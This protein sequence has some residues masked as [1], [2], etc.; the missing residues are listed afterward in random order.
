MKEWR[1]LLDPDY[2]SKS[3]ILQYSYIFDNHRWQQKV[4]ILVCTVITAPIVCCDILYLMDMI[5]DRSL[6]IVICSIETTF[7]AV[8]FILSF[9]VFRALL[10]YHGKY[11]FNQQ[12]KFLLKLPIPLVIVITIGPILSTNIL[13]TTIYHLIVLSEMYMICWIGFIYFPVYI[14][15]KQYNKIQYTKKS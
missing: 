11:Y 13:F 6:A 7:F 4:S 1:K 2:E 8:F 14:I 3:F 5:Q 15:R 9:F 12:G 10:L